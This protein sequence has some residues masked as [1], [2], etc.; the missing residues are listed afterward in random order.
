MHVAGRLG[1]RSRVLSRHVSHV[2]MVFH[3]S[4]SGFLVVLVRIN[5]DTCPL[6]MNFWLNSGSYI[7]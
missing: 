5:E 3:S 4:A 7:W 1:L 6:Q 2:S